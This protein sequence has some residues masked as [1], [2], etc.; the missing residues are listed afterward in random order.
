MTPAGGFGMNTGLQDVQNLAWKLTAVLAGWAGPALLETYECERQP[1]DRWITAQTLRNLA[2]IRRI[3]SG[4]ASADTS[5][6]EGR[7]EFFHEQGMIFAAAYES[8][9]VLPDGT[10]PPEVTNPVTDYAP[11]AHPGCRAP[12]IWLERAGQRL[13]TLDLF[14]TGFVL[15]AGRTGT[16]WCQAAAKIAHA[17]HVPLHAF[18]VGAQGD[19]IDPGGSWATTYGVEQDGALLVRPDGHVAWRARSCVTNPAEILQGVLASILGEMANSCLPKRVC[20][21]VG[22]TPPFQE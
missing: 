13:S 21:S 15:L 6:Y 1:V 5:M 7:Q 3:G 11:T 2:S 9:A 16:A 20:I 19:L 12:H 14:G 22:S 18:T 8:A 17:R 4:E 10:A